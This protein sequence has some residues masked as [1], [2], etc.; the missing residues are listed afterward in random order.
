GYN[1]TDVRKGVYI[2]GH[3][4]EDVVAYR[5]QF[6]NALED[7]WPFM[8]EFEDDGSIKE[9]AYPLGCEV[10]GLTRPIIL[11]THDESTF[12]S[13]DSWRQAWAADRGLWYRSFCYLGRGYHWRAFP[14]KSDKPLVYLHKRLSYWNMGEKM[15]TG[16]VDI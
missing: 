16:K 6:V 12:S 5:E 11:I 8:V 15:A 4:R 9:K 1:Y 2:D 10:G 13:N 7:L 3:E 14:I